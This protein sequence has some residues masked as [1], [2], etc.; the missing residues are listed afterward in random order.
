MRWTTVIVTAIVL[1]LGDAFLTNR[2]ASANVGGAETGI[3]S[4]LGKF[5]DASV[6]AFSSSSSSSKTTTSTSA[7]APPTTATANQ[8]VAA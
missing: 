2:S 5:L 8:P 4:L 3:A 1:A 7:A 6:P